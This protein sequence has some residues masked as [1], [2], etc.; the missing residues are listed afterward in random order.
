MQKKFPQTFLFI[1]SDQE[2]RKHCITT[3][4]PHFGRKESTKV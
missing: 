2:K 1:R 4:W 3:F